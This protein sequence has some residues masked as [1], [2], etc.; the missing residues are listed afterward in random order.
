MSAPVQESMQSTSG[1]RPIPRTMKSSESRGR[2]IVI[3]FRSGNSSRSHF[4]R[5]FDQSLPGPWNSVRPSRNEKL[6]ELVTILAE[7]VDEEKLS[8]VQAFDVVQAVLSHE[9]R[10]KVWAAMGSKAR[11]AFEAQVW[12][13]NS[14]AWGS[15]NDED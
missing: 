6:G 8:K 2:P 13:M 15:R 5:V 11:S 12:P 1:D 10:K 9:A 4:T 14:P 7:L 3:A